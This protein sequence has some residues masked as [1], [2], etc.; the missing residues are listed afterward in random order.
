MSNGLLAAL[1]G[2]LTLATVI[3][4]VI[5]ALLERSGPIRLRAFAEEAGGSLRRL[6]DRPQAFEAFRHLL[7]LG[8]KV[9]LAAL[10]LAWYRLYLGLDLALDRALLAAL[11]T[12]ALVAFL[13]ELVSRILIKR[14]PEAALSRLTWLYRFCLVLCRPVLPLATLL[15]PRV[16][17]LDGDEEEEDEA[18]EEEID[19]FIAV[20]EHEGILERDQGEMVRSV[21]DFG[22]TQ[23]KSVMT[24]RIDMVCAP[25]TT[26]LPEL[27]D[28]FLETRRS[29]I[30]LFRDSIDQVV[31]VL[32]V[33]ELL[34]GLHREPGASA[35]ALA[36]PPY[37]VP[38]TKTLSELL[39]EFQARFEQM[40]I[41][42]D[43]Y[44]GVAGLVTLEDL[45]EEIVGDI[46]DEHEELQEGPQ[47]LEEGVWRVDGRA[48][49]EELGDVVGV[50]ID[51]G[52]YETVG[53]LVL[54]VLGE[55]PEAGAA[56]VT[57]GLKLTV[58]KVTDRRIEVV[59]VERAVAAEGGEED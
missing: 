32:H 17:E 26:S 54:H 19:A 15:M 20:G 58:E 5:S 25:E 1:A 11:G 30:P 7:S 4:I 39:R 35:L 38:P 18:S 14:D 42:V 13:V 27:A 53:G 41:V 51:D 57:H 3:S 33:R 48:H 28:R 16:V 44:G 47:T 46:A 23:V 2:A 21:V 56:V 55:V 49:V 37:F 8:A 34:R 22:E 6:Y 9:L 10:A 43:E 59:R 24:P 40:A 50:S 36:R 45:V 12:A 52:P 31:G 29:R